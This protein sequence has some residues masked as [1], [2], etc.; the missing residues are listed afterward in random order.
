[1][2]QTVAKNTLCQP[3][4]RLRLERFLL[5]LPLADDVRPTKRQRQQGDQFLQ[6]LRLNH[7]PLF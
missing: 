4:M 6:P 7:V 2:I 5:A 1:M 3:T